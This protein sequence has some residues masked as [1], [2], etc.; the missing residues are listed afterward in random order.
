MTR[1]TLVRPYSLTCTHYKGK[2]IRVNKRQNRLKHVD[3]EVNT[4]SIGE[5]KN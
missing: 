2:K 3:D 4:P 5:V 1:A